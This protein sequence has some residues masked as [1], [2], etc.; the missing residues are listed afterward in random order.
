[1][2]CEPKTQLGDFFSK[3]PQLPPHSEP[4]QEWDFMRTQKSG[5]SHLRLKLEPPRQITFSHNI[6]VKFNFFIN[7]IRHIFHYTN[8]KGQY[9]KNLWL[10]MNFVRVQKPLTQG[11]PKIWRV[12]EMSS[13]VSDVSPPTNNLMNFWN[14][15]S[16]L[17]WDGNVLFTSCSQFNMCLKSIFFVSAQFSVF[18]F[19]VSSSAPAFDSTLNSTNITSLYFLSTHFHN[20]A[21]PFPVSQVPFLLLPFYFPVTIKCDFYSLFNRVFHSLPG[22]C[23]VYSSSFPRRRKREKWFC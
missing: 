2:N 16:V 6:R 9:Q 20:F 23:I 8:I 1:M 13:Q 10:K 4:S 15:N 22:N 18:S 14:I 17:Q 12:M 5:S 7:K 3:P 21:F 19:P 11:D